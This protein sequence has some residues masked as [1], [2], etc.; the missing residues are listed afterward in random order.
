MRRF[1]PHSGR[2][3][4]RHAT[5]IAC[6]AIR[7]S[8]FRLVGDL[9]VDISET[10]MLVAPAEPVLTGES[11]MVSFKTPRW[12]RWIDTEATVV[13]VAHGRRAADGARALGLRFD[14]LDPAARYI[15]GLSMRWMPPAPPRP[16]PGRRLTTPHVRRLAQTSWRPATPLV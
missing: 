4:P 5:R 3:P 12:G 1:F 15:L 6:Q 8:D 11:L 2:R 7:M 10:G 16:R 13:R 14:V 9:I